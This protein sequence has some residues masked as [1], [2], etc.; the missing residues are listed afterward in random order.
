M[1]KIVATF[2]NATYNNGLYKDNLEFIAWIEKAATMPLTKRYA[3]I[4]I[5]FNIKPK[6]D[7]KIIVKII[8]V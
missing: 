1:K 3:K 2:A 8:A 7:E 4:E 6:T 5:E